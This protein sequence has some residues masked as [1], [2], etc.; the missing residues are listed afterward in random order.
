MR[1]SIVRM[2]VSIIWCLIGRGP[3]LLGEV[4]VFLS[5]LID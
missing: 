2:I 5:T 1:K 3:F 4:D